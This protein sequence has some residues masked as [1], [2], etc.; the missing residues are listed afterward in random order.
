MGEVPPASVVFA[1][2]DRSCRG[3]PDAV[4]LEGGVFSYVDAGV[5]DEQRHAY[6]PT[7][8][9]AARPASIGCFQEGAVPSASNQCL[10]ANF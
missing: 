10:G 9:W 2:D 1:A 5:A 6:L 4:Y 7:L 8:C 3:G